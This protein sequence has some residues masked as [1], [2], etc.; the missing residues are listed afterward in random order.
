MKIFYLKAAKS[1]TTT[2]TNIGNLKLDSPYD[3][4]VK[5][6]YCFLPFSAGQ[7]MKGTIT[8]FKDTMVY[9]VVSAY[10][11]TSVQREIFRQM[12]SDG[13]NVTIETNGVYY[14]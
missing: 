13:I 3:E 9:T 10:K 8:S 6:I 11:D 12:A 5:F 14:E 2:I 1:N 4:Y 7:R